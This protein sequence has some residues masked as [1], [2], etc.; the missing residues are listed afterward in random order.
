M[1]C[2]CSPQLAFIR[3]CMPSQPWPARWP[4]TWWTAGRLRA[5]DDELLH[6][7]RR[8]RPQSSCMS[9]APNPERPWWERAC[10]KDRMTRCA[11]RREQV[12]AAWHASRLSLI[13]DAVHMR[14]PAS[15]A[16]AEEHRTRWLAERECE[17][18]WCRAEHLRYQC[19]LAALEEPREPSGSLVQLILSNE[20]LADWPLGPDDLPA[21][22]RSLLSDGDSTAASRVEAHLAEH[23]ESAACVERERPR[24]VE[25]Q[26][27]RQK[28]KRQR[29]A[30]RDRQRAE[31]RREYQA[32]VRGL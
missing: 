17:A 27:E 30:E 10:C 19:S 31:E 8:H 25:L 18:R 13:A 29:R 21:V 14:F 1:A 20:A 11:H 7:L 12:D 15:S 3:H 23:R 6:Y 28:R 2:A 9:Y 4:T 22:L 16:A 26:R 5:H 32:A 24:L